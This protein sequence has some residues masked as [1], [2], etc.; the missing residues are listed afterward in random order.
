MDYGG[1]QL[2]VL[3][4]VITVHEAAEMIGGTTRANLRKV[5]RRCANGTYKARQDSAGTWLILKSSVKAES[6]SK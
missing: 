4:Q 3:E 2:S 5:Q 6:P 1:D